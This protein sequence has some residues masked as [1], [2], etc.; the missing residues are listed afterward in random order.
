MASNLLL[1]INYISLKIN[2]LIKTINI[3]LNNKD[4]KYLINIFN[5]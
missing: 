5:R 1:K 3:L 4:Y 2:I